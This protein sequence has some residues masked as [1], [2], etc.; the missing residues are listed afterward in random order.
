MI[1][2]TKNLQKTAEILQSK[3]LTTTK[4]IE[5][6]LIKKK[7]LKNQPHSPSQSISCAPNT[8]RS[9]LHMQHEHLEAAVIR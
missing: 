9:I 8:K 2:E 1:I 5:N 3:S 7:S 6:N 4:K